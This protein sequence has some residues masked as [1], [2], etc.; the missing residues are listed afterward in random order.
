M[1]AIII[2]DDQD[3]LSVYNDYLKQLGHPQAELVSDPQEFFQNN[4][5]ASVIE[6]YDL[7]ICDV[8]MPNIKGNQILKEFVDTRQTMNRFPSFIL[9]T[10]V[11]PEYFTFDEQGWGSLA[12]ADDILGKPVEIEEFDHALRR[13]GFFGKAAG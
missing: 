7:V 2:D 11:A 10:G 12:A 5:I 13:Q 6:N 3:I 9:I 4:S 8:H 1:R